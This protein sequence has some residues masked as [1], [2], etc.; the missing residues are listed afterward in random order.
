MNMNYIP[1]YIVSAGLFGLFIGFSIAF[2]IILT[3]NK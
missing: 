1:L 3:T 2:L